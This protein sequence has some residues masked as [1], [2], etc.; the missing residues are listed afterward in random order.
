MI[1]EI[2]ASIV[3]AVTCALAVYLIVQSVKNKEEY[4]KSLAMVISAYTLIILY[5][6]YIL[7]I[8]DDKVFTL[9]S[10]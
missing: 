10:I 8:A 9:W 6:G 1:I 3:V 7:F 4:L 2:A 5:F